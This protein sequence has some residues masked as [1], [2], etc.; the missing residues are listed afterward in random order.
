MSINKIKSSF[1]NNWRANKNPVKFKSKDNNRKSDNENGSRKH[2]TVKVNSNQIR[3][4]I[5][6]DSMVNPVK[7]WELSAS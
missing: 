6:G 5:V 2:D 3:T 1:S 7:G 4:F